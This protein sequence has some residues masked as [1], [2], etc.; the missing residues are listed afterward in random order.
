MLNISGLHIER[1]ILPIFNNTLHKFSKEKLLKLLNRPLS[2]IPAI[3]LRQNILKGFSKHHHVLKNYGYPVSYLLE[4]YVFLESDDLQDLS[5]QKF[6]Y[7]LFASGREK[8]WMR[9]KFSQVILLFDRLYR[10]YFSRLKL[11]HFPESYSIELRRAIDLMTSLPLVELEMAIRKSKFKDR[12]V[13]QL[14]QLLVEMKSKGELAYIWEQLFLFEAYLSISEAIQTHQFTYPVFSKEQISLCDFYHP[15]LTNPVKNSLETHNKV[16]LLTGA[17]M[18]GKST[19]LKALG[20][21][22]YLAHLGVGIPAKNGKVPFFDHFFI[23]I[24]LSDDLPNGYSRFMLEV[25]NVKKV[26]ELAA[27]GSKC[28]AIFDELFSGTNPED[29][30]EI[31]K[32]TL[33]GLSQFKD[34]FFIISSHLQQ[35]KE[36]EIRDLSVFHLDC[37]L[38]NDIP[39]FTYELKAGWSDVKVGRILFEQEGLNKLLIDQMK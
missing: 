35:L 2:G 31:C 7:K 37:K 28:F 32:T 25:K 14:S 22:I 39:S 13:I 1:E 11:S 15:L 9:S 24:N 26:L 6:Q 10:H 21:C 27:T 17:N 18:S 36:V 33:G 29:A 20:F 4:S 30:F 38:L 5:Q 19:L 8:N 16:I 23:G 12:D 3:E 34:S